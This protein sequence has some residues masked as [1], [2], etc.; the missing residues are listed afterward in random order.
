[1]VRY[2]VCGSS[3]FSKAIFDLDILDKR[4]MELFGD[5]FWDDVDEESAPSLWERWIQTPGG[6]TISFDDEEVRSVSDLLDATAKRVC[7]DPRDRVYA[8]Y[9]LLPGLRNK[10]PPDYTKP[11]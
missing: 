4:L 5:D 7:R 6:F 3:Q 8:L 2:F 1:V 10:H 9:G 11:I